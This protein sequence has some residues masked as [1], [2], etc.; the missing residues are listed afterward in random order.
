MFLPKR[1]I[2][3]TK[4]ETATPENSGFFVAFI[5]VNESTTSTVIDHSSNL[6]AQGYSY[7]PDTDTWQIWLGSVIRTY[8]RYRNV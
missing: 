3:G 2:P 7:D 6:I 4:L 1:R 8:R 5:P